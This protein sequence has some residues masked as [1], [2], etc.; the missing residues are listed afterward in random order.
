M[1]NCPDIAQ[2][3]GLERSSGMLALAMEFV[4]GDDLA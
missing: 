4:D 1:L 3:Y 2:I